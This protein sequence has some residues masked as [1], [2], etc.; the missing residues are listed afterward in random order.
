MS[1]ATDPIFWQRQRRLPLPVMRFLRS[2]LDEALG[3]PA[4]RSLL[5]WPTILGAPRL[6]ET[7]PEGIPEEELLAQ[8]RRML[9]AFGILD[10]LEAWQES[11]LRFPHIAQQGPGGWLPGPL[12]EALAP[13]LSLRSGVILVARTGQP[14]DDR[15]RLSCAVALFNMALFHECHDALEALW[16]GSSG[17]LKEG[18]QGLILMSA[19]FYHQQHHDAAGMLALWRDGLPMLGRFG[20]RL[21]T[22]WGTVDFRESLATASGRLDWLMA[23]DDEADLDRLW[24]MPRPEWSLT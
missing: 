21:E 12:W 5:V 6:R 19:G 1:C 8:S 17:G 13:E 18:L 14:E 7:H 20:E 15:Y 23:E 10:P 11:L 16:L 9:E 24:E 22:P 3:D 2:L 4:Q